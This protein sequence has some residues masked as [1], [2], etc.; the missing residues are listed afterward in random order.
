MT[1][2][3]SFTELEKHYRKRLRD[4]IE[5]S[6]DAIDVENR[7]QALTR[8]F[9]RDALGMAESDELAKSALREDF[10]KLTP[11]AP[12]YLLSSEAS[13][14]PGLSELFAGS[15]LPN[16]LERFAE[17]A[18]RGRAYFKGLPGKDRSV[19]GQKI[20]QQIR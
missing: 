20:K 4:G 6:E 3:R 7:F 11:E 1:A 12:F 14:L 10:V 17:S 13:A 16:I 5:K 19:R 8:D 9:L 15:D 18:E 2:Q